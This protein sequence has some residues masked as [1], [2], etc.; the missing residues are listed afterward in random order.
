RT[1]TLNLSIC[2]GW[3][4]TAWLETD[5]LTVGVFLVAQSFGIFFLV[6][7]AAAAPGELN[8]YEDSSMVR[9]SESD[10]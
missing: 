6:S 9:I 7:N 5:D 4:N 2:T 1:S 10:H 3:C 8:R